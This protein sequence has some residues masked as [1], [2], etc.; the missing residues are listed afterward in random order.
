M[1]FI[2]LDDNIYELTNFT[3]VKYHII[4]G[5]DNRIFQYFTKTYLPNGVIGYADSR[6]DDDILYKNLAF[7]YNT[8]IP[9]I[10]WGIDLSEMMR[11]NKNVL[12]DED[13]DTEYLTIWDCGYTQWL[14]ERE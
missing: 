10:E 11:F 6:W 13:I 1:S 7:M 5:A 8:D 12:L 9:I 3:C 2:D 14:W 4:N